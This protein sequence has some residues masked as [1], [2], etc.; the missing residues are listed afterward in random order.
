MSKFRPGFSQLII[1]SQEPNRH[2]LGKMEKEV[3]I[4]ADLGGIDLGEALDHGEDSVDDIV[5]R[6]M[7]VAVR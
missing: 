4:G 5:F 1:F 2:F 3:G 6:H 7:I